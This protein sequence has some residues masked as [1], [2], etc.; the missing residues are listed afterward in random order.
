[1]TVRFDPDQC[2]PADAGIFG[3]PFTPQEARLVLVPVGWDATTSYRAGTHLGPEAIRAASHQLDLYDV[4]LGEFWR[5]GIAMLPQL[6]GIAA[7]NG[8]A[9]A[10][11]ER[12]IAVGGRVGRDPELTAAL[13]RVNAASAQVNDI[14]Y[15]AVGEQLDRNKLVGVVGGDHST[16]YGAIRRLGELH[17]DFGILHIDA[18]ADLRVAYEGF[19]WSHASI[20]HNVLRDVP[21]VSKLVQVGIRD[22]CKAEANAITGSDGRVRTFYDTQLAT[23]AFAGESW[24]AV[25]S[26]IVEELPERVYISFDIDG[27]DPA[28]CPHTGTPVPG[29]LQFHQACALIREVVARGRRIV[30]F[31]LNEVA[32]GDDEWDANVGARVLYKLCGSMLKSWS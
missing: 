20:M 8:D 15:R 7:L 12:V 18:H 3:L 30:G 17:R 31:D 22:L 26:E 32:P 2:P 1:M 11:A 4:E 13:A 27:L 29:G 16:P 25:V 14:V 23:R 21:A 10:D 28:L 9:R 6:D 5:G 24:A 19:E